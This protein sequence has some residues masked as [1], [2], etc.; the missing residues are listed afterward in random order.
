MAYKDVATIVRPAINAMGYECWGI[1]FSAYRYRA[2]LRVFID[3]P[4]GVSLDDCS[5]V[6]QQ[7]GGLLDAENVIQGPYTLEISSPGLE[8]LLLEP[9]HYQ[10]YI[11]EKIKLE[12]HR[13][14][15]QKRKMTGVIK[16]VDERAV[17]VRLDQ[18]T[19]QVP[20]ADIRRANLVFEATPELMKRKQR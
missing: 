2:L 9:A 11:G 5:Q 12:L 19:V 3:H 18:V 7:L 20:F 16:A 17:E 4:N 15:D 14:I 10:R 8:R 1:Q 6:S 13:V